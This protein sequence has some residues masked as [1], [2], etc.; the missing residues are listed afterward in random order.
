MV[1]SFK[2]LRL[3]VHVNRKTHTHTHTH[4][5]FDTQERSRSLFSS[6]QEIFKYDLNVPG[7]NAPG[8]VPFTLGV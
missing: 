8:C 1:G 2:E 4:T 5:Q 3:P 7:L 6:L